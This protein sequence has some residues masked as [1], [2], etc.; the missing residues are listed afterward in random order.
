MSILD[1]IAARVSDGMLFPLFPRAVGT[2]AKRAMLIAEGLWNFISEPGPDQEWEIRKGFLQA[3]LETFATGDPIGPKYLFLLSPAR[4]GVWEIR[5]ARPD[6][7]IRVLGLFIGKD[8]F[9]ATNFAL[10][11]ELEG[12]ETR[13]WRDSKLM[14]RTVW[15]NLFH[16]YRPRITSDINHVVSGA[17][18]GKYFKGG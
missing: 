12:W 18:N 6:P 7:S 17:I 10:R 15:T 11:S 8:I 14:A 1:L 5:S 9:V 16:T 3:D 13:A 2:S 4:E